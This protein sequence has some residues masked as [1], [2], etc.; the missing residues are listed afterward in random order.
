MKFFTFVVVIA[1]AFHPL[2]SRTAETANAR[3]W[4]LSLRFQQG[5]DSFGD[6]LDLSTISSTANGE[7]TPYNSQTYISGFTLDISGLPI[8]GTM[9]L[10][11]PPFVDVNG[12]GFHDFFESAI[13]VSATTTGTYTAGSENGTVTATWQRGAGSAIG[14]CSLHLV[15]NTFGDLGSFNH[16]FSLLEYIG[17]L[18]FTP[19]SN[20][21]S[22]SVN[23][24]NTSDQTTQIQGPVQFAKVSTNRLNQLMLQPGNWTNTASQTLSYTNDLYQRIPPWT[25]NYYGL[26]E[27]ADGDPN[28]AEPDYLTWVCSIDDLNDANHNGIPDFS[29]DPQTGSPPPTPPQLAFTLTSSNL[30]ISV[31]GD[32][33]HRLDLQQTLSLPATNWQTVVSL[34]LTNNAQVVSISNPAAPAAFWRALGH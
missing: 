31:S 8:N 11:L 25:T 12:N 3:I 19:G 29:D 15:D 26:V 17:P 13:G 21:V 2:I 9:Q 32:V 10:N 14:S 23:L 24:T 28:T 20:V 6:T 7:L 33:G 1:T 34:T 22:E 16:V 4:C 18:L 30:L 5:T 27:F